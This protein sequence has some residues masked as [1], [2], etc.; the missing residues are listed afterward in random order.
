MLAILGAGLSGLSVARALL[1]EGVRDRL[2]LVDRRTTFERDRTWCLWDTQ[3]TPL[4]ALAD[5][6]WASWRI[7]GPDGRAVVHHAP[8]HPY[9]HVA[10]DRFYADALAALDGRAE[11]RLGERVLDVAGGG[12]GAEGAVRVRTTGGALDARLAIDARGWRGEAAL[13]Q[14]FLGLEVETDAPVFDPA[15][16][17]LMDFRLGE[18]ADPRFAYVLPFSPTRALV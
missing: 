17:T 14:R 11:L 10:A 9:V 15:V 6:A 1:D 8:R 13:W 4:A 2:V 5:H 12:A 7:V 3:T 18:A 16:A